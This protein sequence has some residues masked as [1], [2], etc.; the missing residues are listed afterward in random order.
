[1]AVFDKRVIL[2]GSEGGAKI[3]TSKTCLGGMDAGCFDKNNL[4]TA[5]VEAVDPIVLDTKLVEVCDRHCCNDCDLSEIPGCICECFCSE[6]C[7][8]D[9]GKRVLLT[10]GQFS[11]VRLERDTQLLIP[12][13]SYCMPEKEC[14]CGCGCGCG[15][16]DPCDLFRSIAFPVDEF[17]PPNAVEKKCDYEGIKC[18]C[19]SKR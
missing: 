9:R 15:T 1:M 4:P 16:A 18:R 12:T 19:C 7:S 6:L 17:F 14:T 13:Y 2:F 5:V 11:I 3:F 10:L 8:N